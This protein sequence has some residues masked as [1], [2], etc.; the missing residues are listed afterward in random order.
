MAT[1]AIT[2]RLII[3]SIQANP[4]VGAI[5]A[6]AALAKDLMA[7]ATA[8]G[9]DVA[10]FPE[11]FLIGYPPEDLALKP[12]ALRDCRAALDR[13]AAETAGGCAALITL[14]CPHPDG[15]PRNAVALIDGG[16]VKRRRL[17]DGPPQLRRVRREAHLRPRRRAGPVRCARCA[18]S[19][20]RSARTSGVGVPARRSRRRGRRCCSFPNGSPY[21]R[22]STAERMRIAKARVA[23]TGLPMIY[24]NQ[25]G[26]Q[27]EL[28]FD[29]GSFAL[30]SRAARW[31]RRRPPFADD[32]SISTWERGDG[33]LALC[34]GPARRLGRAARGLLPR[35]GR[36]PA[37]LCAQIRL[38][39]RAARPVRRG[40]FG[41]QPRGG[42]GRP[43]TRT[44]SAR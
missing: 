8:M 27:D 9:A 41:D 28:V 6:N 19:E 36:R 21:R 32:L 12:A 30:S 40:R 39:G 18:G 16:E 10:L 3:A 1:T 34:R 37:R 29:G 20:R 25:V 38:Q 26:G 22:T 44:T 2:N 42:A 15:H 23:E 35:H 24:V 14:A 17:Q 33:W 11:L 4:T 7:R 5:E 31:S 43:R 13:L